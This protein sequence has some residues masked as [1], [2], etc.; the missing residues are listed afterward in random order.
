MLQDRFSSVAVS[1]EMPKNRC[2]FSKA[3]EDVEM[4]SPPTAHM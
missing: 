3:G 2:L 1:G 4:E